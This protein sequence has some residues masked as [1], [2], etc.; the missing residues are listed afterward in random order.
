MG[1]FQLCVFIRKFTTGGQSSSDASSDEEDVEP[2]KGKPARPNESVPLD[3]VVVN[4][5]DNI[6]DGEKEEETRM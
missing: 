1:M 4:I 2:N 6:E 5:E 3:S